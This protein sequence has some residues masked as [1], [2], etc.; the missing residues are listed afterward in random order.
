VSTE[1]SSAN[2]PSQ[3]GK[4]TIH[5]RLASRI[6]K[7]VLL[8]EHRG[9]F[10]AIKI[11]KNA[12]L[13]DD[14][15]RMRFDQEV[16]NLRKL[17]HPAIPKIVD[18]DLTDAMQPWIATEFVDGETIQER[19][20]ENKPL[21]IQEWFK[22]LREIADALTYIHGEGI[23]HRD[24]SPSNIIL[25]SDSAKLIDFGLSFLEHSQSLTK[26]G[27]NVQ[28][29]PGTVSPESLSFK[30]DSKMDMFSLGST[31]AFA[32]TGKFPFDN[33][34]DSVGSWMQSIL[35]EEP[36]YGNLDEN[37]KKI[38]N[39]LFYKRLEDRVS[40]DDLQQILR[41]IELD[42]DSIVFNSRL[43]EKYL[44]NYEEKISVKNFSKIKSKKQ[45]RFVDNRLVLVSFLIL[46]GLV[47]I[48]RITRFGFVDYLVL[49]LFG[50]FPLFGLMLGVTAYMKGIGRNKW[51]KRKKLRSIGVGLFGILAPSAATLIFFVGSVLPST[52]ENSLNSL[53]NS[54]SQVSESPLDESSNSTLT[55]MGTNTPSKLPEPKSSAV[56]QTTEAAPS[57]KKV[58]PSSK[59]PKVTAAPVATSSSNPNLSS[60]KFKL[61]AP[62]AK[63]FVKDSLFG[64][65]WKSMDMYW[66]V[67]LQASANSVVPDLTGIQ[68]R[69]IGNSEGP[70][71]EVPYILKVAELDKTVYAQVDAFLFAFLSKNEFCPEFRVV[72]EV[73]GLIT[74][75]W[76][77]S[78]PECSNN[79]NP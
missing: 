9:Q 1:R 42:D 26:T 49:F 75:V 68:F 47:I 14:R 76:D 53:F 28:G 33:E 78:L 30:K 6:D 65:P 44:K 10:A 77:K 7:F 41:E 57:P 55:P 60:D 20:N 43:L 11:L 52:F 21:H 18:L 46:L 66:N 15:E 67:P 62:L 58:S 2:F 35:Y 17:D 8:G 31:F 61:S 22:A 39:P 56:S 45:F 69:P 24:V 64:R 37:R 4:W 32:A 23:Y 38:L 12:D 59:A 27:I 5:K 29:T 19:I 71:F 79:Y 3:L 25:S 73:S 72:K 70:W 16:Q 50:I 63:D 74:K 40:S 48:S 54:N 36:D 13:L 34:V 51:G